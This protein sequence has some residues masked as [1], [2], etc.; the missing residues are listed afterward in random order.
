MLYEIKNELNLP[1]GKIYTYSSCEGEEGYL[2]LPTAA[3]LYGK[4]A[5]EELYPLIE[6]YAVYLSAYAMPYEAAV[7]VCRSESD[8][9]TLIEM[10]LTRADTLSVLLRDTEFGGMSGKTQIYHKGRCVAMLLYDD[11]EEA[12]HTMRRALG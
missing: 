1:S 2:P 11:P 5:W 10:C 4:D 3:A 12:K 6:D 8:T 7:F 9:D